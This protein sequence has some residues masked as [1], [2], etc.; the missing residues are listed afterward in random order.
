LDALKFGRF[1]RRCTW[2]EWRIDPVDVAFERIGQIIELDR[3]A[4]DANAMTPEGDEGPVR[5]LAHTR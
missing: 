2:V 3:H 5:F 4:G 1:Y